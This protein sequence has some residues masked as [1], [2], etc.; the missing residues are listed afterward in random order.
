MMTTNVTPTTLDRARSYLDGAIVYAAEDGDEDRH[1]LLVHGRARLT[2]YDRAVF[3]RLLADAGFTEQRVIVALRSIEHP[4]L[5]ALRQ[6][7]A[8]ALRL[9]GAT[10]LAEC[11][12]AR[13][14]CDDVK[15]AGC[16]VAHQIAKG[17]GSDEHE[18]A[19]AV[20][21]KVADALSYRETL[22]RAVAKVQEKATRSRR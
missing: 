10:K 19:M 12:Q 16:L 11:I 22:D 2:S 1:Q 13:E 9:V 7:A 21:Y 4:D 20:L 17:H 18:V 6:Q 14:R 3:A 15:R 8:Q 5:P